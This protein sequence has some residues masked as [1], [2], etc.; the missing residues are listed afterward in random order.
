MN[1]TVRGLIRFA[2]RGSLFAVRRDVTLSLSKGEWI[3]FAVC[4]SLFAVCRDV[5]LSLSKGEWILFAVRCSR[6]AV[7]H[8]VTLS[9]S[10][11][12]WIFCC[13][14]PLVQLRRSNAESAKARKGIKVHQSFRKS[15]CIRNSSLTPG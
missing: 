14:L 12:E 10:K 4:G 7:C 8:D 6:F 3:L 9:L 11:G 1:E 2:V 15:I 13:Y 5:T